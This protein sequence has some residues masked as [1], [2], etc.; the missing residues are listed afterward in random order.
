MLNLFG[1][2]VKDAREKVFLSADA[3]KVLTPKKTMHSATIDGKELSI[4][5]RV[6]KELEQIRDVLDYAQ[7]YPPEESFGFI[8]SGEEIADRTDPERRSDA[9]MYAKPEL[10]TEKVRTLS[11]DEKMDRFAWFVSICNRLTDPKLLELIIEQAPKKKDGTFA[12][13]RLTVIAA[14]PVVFFSFMDYY[15]I[16]GTAKDDT[17]LQLSIR[18]RTFSEDEWL[19]TKVTSSFFSLRRVRFPKSQRR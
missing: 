2:N 16:V 14:M 8:L 4:T 11:M 7:N 18:R 10:D 13:N 1:I 17:H 9:F 15:E 12:R 6:G 19:R 5:Y 3:K